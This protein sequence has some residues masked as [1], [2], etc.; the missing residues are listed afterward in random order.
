[1]DAFVAIHSHL[2]HMGIF[3]DVVIVEH[4][5][6]FA[7]FEFLDPGIQQGKTQKQTAQIAVGHHVGIV[8]IGFLHLPVQRDHIHL[9][10]RRL[11]HFPEAHH[12]LI[13]EI[14][15]GF[16]G[17][18]GDEQSKTPGC[19][20]AVGQRIAQF[21][22][23]FQGS[24]AHGDADIRG[25][26][27]GFGDGAFGNTQFPGDIFQSGQ[28]DHLPS[29]GINYGDYTTRFHK[30]QTLTSKTSDLFR[31]VSEKETGLSKCNKMLRG[32]LVMLTNIP[33]GMFVH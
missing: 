21:H 18:I 20:A 12:N 15:G 27:E 31:T 30:M 22:G 23:F 26:V 2:G 24:G 1:M 25:A 3:L 13:A 9:V 5:G 19:A 16:A 10:S 29:N 4:R 32:H 11:R 6:G 28:G 7:G 17:H 14:I 8:V 33:G